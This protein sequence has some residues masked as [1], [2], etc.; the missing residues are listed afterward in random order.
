MGAV[1]PL[2]DVAVNVVLVPEQIVVL[3]VMLTEGKT[4][5]LIIC[6]IVLLVTGL[7]F[8][9][10]KLLVS[11]TLITSL[12]FK[13]FAV[14]V[15]ELKPAFTPLTFHWYTGDTPAFVVVAV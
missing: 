11:T 4:L 13:L 6:T 2:V 14:K 15:F 12:L 5:L 10:A 3:P 7:L 9:Q 1:P 8:T